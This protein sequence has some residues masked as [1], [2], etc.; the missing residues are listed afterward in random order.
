MTCRGAMR[1]LR[2]VV[3]ALLA[4]GQASGECVRAGCFRLRD[5]SWY[6]GAADDGTNLGADAD[7]L[8]HVEDCARTGDPARP[9]CVWLREH[10]LPPPPWAK[11]LLPPTGLRIVR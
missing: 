6:R 9:S 4:M 1:R 11:P 5:D 8:V 2:L 3:V 10:P 7:A